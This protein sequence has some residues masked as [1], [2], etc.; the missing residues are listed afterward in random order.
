MKTPEQ[1]DGLTLDAA[2]LWSKWGFNDGDMPD[3]LDGMNWQKWD[4][5]LEQLIRQHLLPLLDGVEIVVWG[6]SHNP[7][8]ATTF[9]QDMPAQFE[10]VSVTILWDA[11]RAILKEQD[12]G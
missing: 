6:T 8:R 3:E 1:I 2:S 10:G 4:Q 9:G 5:V 12:D 11:V 7:F